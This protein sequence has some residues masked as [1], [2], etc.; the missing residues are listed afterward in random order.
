MPTIF[1]FIFVILIVMSTV[2]STLWQTYTG[3]QNVV[4][5]D[6]NYISSELA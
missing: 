1:I 3:E 6:L 5:A 2:Y 4:N